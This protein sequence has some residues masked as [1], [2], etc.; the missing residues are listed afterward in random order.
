M[1]KLDLLHE[2]KVRAEQ[3]AA[4]SSSFPTSSSSSSSSSSAA[5][6]L[7]AVVSAT[8]A[9]AA[10]APATDYEK[11]A[12]ALENHT[13]GHYTIKTHL[14]SLAALAKALRAG[15]EADDATDHAFRS[16]DQVLL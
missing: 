11:T 1:A 9:P 16:L 15:A 5:E 7:A 2:L 13:A 10:A 3:A 6:P 4:S 8:A 14:Y 12:E